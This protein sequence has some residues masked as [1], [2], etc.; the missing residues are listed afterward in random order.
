MRRKGRHKA[1]GPLPGTFAW[2]QA[3]AGRLFPLSEH[4]RDLIR[5]CSRGMPRRFC[6]KQGG[7]PSSRTAPASHWLRGVSLDPIWRR[8]FRYF[9]CLRNFTLAYY[10]APIYLLTFFFFLISE[11]RGLGSLNMLTPWGVGG[12]VKTSCWNEEGLMAS[13]ALKGRESLLEEPWATRETLGPRLG[14]TPELRSN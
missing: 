10:E 12:E 14:L 1:S 2:S 11:I 13:K 4:P 6:W 5:C 8:G 3:N 9:A 7:I